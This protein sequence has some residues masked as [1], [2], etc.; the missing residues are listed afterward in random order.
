VP[1]VEAVAVLDGAQ[2][3]A[4]RQPWAGLVREEP[5]GPDVWSA[6]AGPTRRWERTLRVEAVG[7][8]RHRVTQCTDYEL[9]LP[10]F[11]WLFA[12]PARREVRRLPLRPSPPWWAPTEALDRQAARAVCCLCILSMAT[13]YL[14][15]LLTQTIA[16]AGQEFGVGSAGQG[17]ALAVS[18]V[19]TVIAFSAV[20]LADRLGRRTVLA[21]AVVVAVSFTALGALAPSLPLLIALQLPSRGL[22]A[23]MNVIIG[24]QAA[25]EV[26]AHAR[27]WTAGVLALINALGAGLCVVTLPV[28]DLGRRGWRI[29]YVVPLLFLPAVVAAVRRLRESRRFLRLQAGRP[30]LPGA[31]PRLRGHSRRLVLLAAG[32]FLA[33]A[34][35]NPAAQLQNTFLRDERG[36]SATRIAL[37]TLLTGT[38]AGIGVVVG[39]RL[40]ERSRRLVGATG[41]VVGTA[42]VV[43]AYLVAGWPL[44][45]FGIVAGIFSAATVPALAVYGPELFPTA[46]RGKANG[47]IGIVSRGG[48]VT[49]LL[50]AALL[51]DRLGGLG[52]ALAVLATGPL[53]LALLVVTLYPETAARELE[54]LN[55]E[56]DRPSPVH[57]APP[58]LP[59]LP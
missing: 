14:G 22:T 15:T 47:V 34:F 5:A 13:G 36:F 3:A 50:G 55:P 17:V 48:A 28:A 19:D 37:F 35:V 53:L 18:R 27:A 4:A 57:S 10:F 2:L 25:E 39:G 26:P 11:G 8:D 33:A 42:F 6:G 52:P 30:L 41:L 38:P 46:L 59:D 58:R 23:A 16:F 44:W 45:A 12:L 49:G 9:D 7:P 43:L 54:D 40:A 32:A 21:T 24:V 51:S 29:S 1:S 31:G 20:V 56:D